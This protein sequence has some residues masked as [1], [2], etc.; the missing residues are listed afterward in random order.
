MK[1]YADLYNLPEDERIQAIAATAAAGNI[2][3]FIVETDEKAD[4]Y[5]AKLKAFPVRVIDRSPGPVRNTI[6]VRVGPKES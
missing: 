3:G 2:V 4:R 6:M 1:A 5:C